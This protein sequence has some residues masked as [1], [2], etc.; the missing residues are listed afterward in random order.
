MCDVYISMSWWKSWNNVLTLY[1]S[2]ILIWCYYLVLKCDNYV[3]SLKT[4]LFDTHCITF[5]SGVQ[6][7]HG[8]D[9]S[10][11]LIDES[12]NGTP[13]CWY[14]I[15]PT[16]HHHHH[17]MHHAMYQCHAPLMHQPMHGPACPLN[18]TQIQPHQLKALWHYMILLL[19]W[20]FICWNLSLKSH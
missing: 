7:S 18:K 5:I 19:I 1:Y 10:S 4:S 6:H 13:I 17:A 11:H 16:P 8:L 20:F 14:L 2:M 15:P 3:L 12:W 9:M